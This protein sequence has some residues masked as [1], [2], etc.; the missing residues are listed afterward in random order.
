MAGQIEKRLRENSSN[1]WEKAGDPDDQSLQSSK[2]ASPEAARVETG[3]S[4]KDRKNWEA[5]ARSRAGLL[6]KG[7]FSE[8]LWGQKTQNYGQKEAECWLQHLY[9]FD[10]RVDKEVR[11]K[12]ICIFGKAKR[13]EKDQL[14]D[15]G[16]WDNDRGLI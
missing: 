4:M 13:R 16:H 5:W 9:E 1:F 12:G 14:G 11:D 3:A 15:P 8:G 10:E 2:K 6:Q 7:R